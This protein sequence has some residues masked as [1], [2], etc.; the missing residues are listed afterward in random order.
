MTFSRAV[1]SGSRFSSWFMKSTIG[2][3]RVCPSAIFRAPAAASKRDE[4]IFSFL[5]NFAVDQERSVNPAVKRINAFII[6]MF[7]FIMK[8]PFND[9]NQH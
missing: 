3:Y 9:L 4:E 5:H 6:L 1:S 2:Q 8:T 7:G